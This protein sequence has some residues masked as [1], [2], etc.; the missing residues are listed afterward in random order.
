[1]DAEIC[2]PQGAKARGQVARALLAAHADLELPDAEG[3]T[4]LRAAAQHG[5]HE[6]R[7]AWLGSEE[8]WPEN[9][10]KA[11]GWWGGGSL[12]VFG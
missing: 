6:A 9:P 7:R 8:R 4:P 12:L 11:P 1:M 5:H 2:G 10:G 3:R